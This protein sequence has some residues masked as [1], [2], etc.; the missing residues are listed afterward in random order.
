MNDNGNPLWYSCLENP[1]DRGASQVKSQTQ[2]SK[3]IFTHK[4]NT[5]RYVVLNWLKHM[6][7]NTSHSLFYVC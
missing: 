7:P 3:F 5:G 1:M 2:L 4:F 6:L